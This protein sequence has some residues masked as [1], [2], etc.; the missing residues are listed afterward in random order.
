M[1]EKRK[2]RRIPISARVK[3]THP[4]IGS[5]IVTTR[6]LSDGGVFLV[7]KGLELPPLGSVLEGQ[8]QDSMENP[9]IV[10]MKIVR[11]ESDGIGVMF[12][13]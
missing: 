2:H 4:S 6:N 11:I 9:P 10:K 7:T 1:N 8:V 3:I 13:N 12:C 5:V